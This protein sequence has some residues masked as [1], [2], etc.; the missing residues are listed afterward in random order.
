M[1]LMTTE[2]PKKILSYVKIFVFFFIYEPFLYVPTLVHQGWLY[3][4]ILDQNVKI[5]S[6]YTE[7]KRNQV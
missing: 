2:N 4:S 7:T 3:V 6:P 1:L 5:Y